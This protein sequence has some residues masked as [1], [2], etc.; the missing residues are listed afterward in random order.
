M[1]FLDL[2]LEINISSMSVEFIPAGSSN[3]MNLTAAHIMR[4]VEPMQTR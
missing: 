3:L 1:S 2:P 4:R